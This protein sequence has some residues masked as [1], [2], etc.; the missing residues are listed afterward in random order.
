MPNTPLKL[1]GIRIDPPPSLPVARVHNPAARAAPAPP[2]DPP[3]V[4]SVFQGLRQ[5]SPSRFSVVPERPN[6]GVLV[7]PRIIA[8]ARRKRSTTT[9]SRSGVRSLNNAEP[10]VVGIPLVISRSFTETGMP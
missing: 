3:G 7:F 4:R 9:E 5:A 2:L 8:P 10:E 6:S 1:A